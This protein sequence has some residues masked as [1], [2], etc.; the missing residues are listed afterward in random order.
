MQK[1]VTDTLDAPDAS[2]SS[3]KNFAPSVK[4]KK[5]SSPLDAIRNDPEA[6]FALLSKMVKDDEAANSD[7]EKSSQVSVSKDPYCQTYPYPQD[8]FGHDEENA[9]DLARDW[10]PCSSGPHK[11]QNASKNYVTKNPKLFQ[12]IPNLAELPF[13]RYAL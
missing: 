6:L 4:S 13:V 12:D 3:T 5:Q 1:D 2:A 9:D 10:F 8:W 7:D 11:G